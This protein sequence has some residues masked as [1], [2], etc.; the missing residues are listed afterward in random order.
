ME[1]VRLWHDPSLNLNAVAHK[2]RVSRDTV[3]N[4]REELGLLRRDE[5]VMNPGRIGFPEP[6]TAMVTTEG[7]QGQVMPPGYEAR[8]DPMKR[9]EIAESRAK[10]VSLAVEMNTNSSLRPTTRHMLRHAFLVALKAPAHTWEGE[11]AMAESLVRLLLT[12][13]KA[14]ADLPPGGA[15]MS[16]LKNEVG[17]KML[18][19]LKSVMNP[20]EEKQLAALMHTGV[21]RLRE[22]REAKER[23]QGGKGAQS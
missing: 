23:Q 12:M 17:A 22:K 21:K 18:S 2:Y 5:A 9:P 19:D 8:W 10:A 6:P 15:D 16:A 11:F 14:E 1:F 3:R 7:A 13:E 20:E 4:W